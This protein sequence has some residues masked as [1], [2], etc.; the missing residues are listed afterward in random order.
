M[1]F[2]SVSD[3]WAIRHF[4]QPLCSLGFVFF[5]SIASSLVL[6]LA[7]FHQNDLWQ[8]MLCVQALIG[9]LIHRPNPYKAPQLAQEQVQLPVAAYPADIRISA[10]CA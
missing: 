8:Q 5:F 1:S 6:H 4:S 2:G 7:A 3:V 9:L 10:E